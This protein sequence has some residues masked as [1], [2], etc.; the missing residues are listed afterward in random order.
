[1]ERLKREL[2][3]RGLECSFR[4]EGFFFEGDCVIPIRVAKPEEIERVQA[5]V[6]CYEP[7]RTLWTLPRY[8]VF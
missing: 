6:A 8:Y 1:M 4:E 5:I 2:E 7:V 3:R